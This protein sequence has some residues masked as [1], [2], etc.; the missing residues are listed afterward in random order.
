MARGH[1]T[2]DHERAQ[3]GSRPTAAGAGGGS[4]LLALQRLVGNQTVAEL[5]AR[6]A[7]Q[8][9]APAVQRA[10]CAGCAAGGSCSS[11]DDGKDDPAAAR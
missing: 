3:P 5:V 4:R 11:V 8:Q 10:C 7:E 1:Q 2:T 6:Q 9:P